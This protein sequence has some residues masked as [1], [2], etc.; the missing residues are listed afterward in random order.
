SVAG[1]RINPGLP[2]AVGL[3]CA[4]PALRA[5]ESL[6]RIGSKTEVHSISFQFEDR[7]ELREDSLRT[8]ISLTPQGS[9]V[10]LRKFFGFL[11]F[12]PP[13]GAH[14]FNPL[15][16]QRDVIRLRNEFHRSG[17]PKAQVKYD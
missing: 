6:T 2:V 11:P 16:L 1:I 3:L 8:R 17:Y 13:V 7:N 15:E 4:V 5:Q 10:G 12:V 14:P 9:M